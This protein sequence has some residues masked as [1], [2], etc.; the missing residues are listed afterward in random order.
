MALTLNELS[1]LVETLQKKVDTLET[2][3]KQYRQDF[4]DLEQQQSESITTQKLTVIGDAQISGRNVQADG[5]RLDTHE[6]RL[7]SHDI[8]I[9][10][11]QGTANDAVN[12]ANN[13]QGTANDA[14]NRANNAQGT[15]NDAVN[16]ANNAQGT[17][18]DAVNRANNAQGTA[19]DAVNR[20]N[21]A[22]GTAN[23]AVNRANNASI[24]NK[25]IALQSVHGGHLSDRN[26]NGGDGRFVGGGI[27]S[28][29]ELTVICL[30]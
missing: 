18:N 11:A 28:W 24:C 19:N 14:V 8:S 23:D 3:V 5:T 20:A 13:A 17:A 16:R 27:G 29:E 9:S 1:D 15:A 26:D 7:N 4:L 2:E 10:S 25:K 30:P 12:G 6:N 21:N 22:Q